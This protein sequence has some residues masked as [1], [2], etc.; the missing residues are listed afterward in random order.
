MHYIKF[1]ILKILSVQFGD[2]KYIHIVAMCNYHHYPFPELFHYPHLKL[3][4]WNI[5]KDSSSLLESL[6]TL[7]L[8]WVEI[9]R[10]GCQLGTGPSWVP[11]FTN[12][13][14]EPRSQASVG[15]PRPQETSRAAGTSWCWNVLGTSWNLLRACCHGSYLGPWEPA[16]AEVSWERFFTGACQKPGGRQGIQLAT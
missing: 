10:Q 11:G 4:W 7:V 8:G 1:N 9:L 2:I 14:L 6:G 12:E 16:S 3:Y 13:P 15:N 5:H